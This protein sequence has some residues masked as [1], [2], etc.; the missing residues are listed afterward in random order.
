M[1]HGKPYERENR[2]KWEDMPD[3]TDY[4]AWLDEIEQLYQEE[5]RGISKQSDISR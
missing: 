4:E 5:D 2:H 1:E 3:P